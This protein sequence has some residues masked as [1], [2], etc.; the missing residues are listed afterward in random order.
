MNIVRRLSTAVLAIMVLL[1]VFGCVAWMS[2]SSTAAG[3]E[4]PMA[5][6]A[7]IDGSQL[8]SHSA[9]SSPACSSCLMT[10]EMMNIPA[11]TQLSVFGFE[12]PALVPMLLEIAILLIAILISIRAPPDW[13]IRPDLIVRLRQHRAV[14]IL[15]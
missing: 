1:G 13:C 7:P 9:H 2:D 15:S 8:V 14:V 4:M 10:Q 5:I 6:H 12:L 11:L 3:M